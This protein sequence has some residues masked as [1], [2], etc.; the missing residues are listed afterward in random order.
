M[1]RFRSLYLF[2]A[3][4]F[5]GGLFSLASAQATPTS[6]AKLQLSAFGGVSGVK[7]GY[8]DGKNLGIT[9]GADFSFWEFHRFHLAA[10]YRGT[11]AIDKGRADSQKVQLAGAQ[12][13]YPIGRFHPYGDFLFG[14]GEINYA[15]PGAQVPNTYIFY[16]YSSSDV[17]SPGAGIDIDL[18]PHFAF[19][20][21]AQ[22]ERYD[23]PVT[24]SGHLTAI[25]GTLGVVY[26]FHFKPYK[27]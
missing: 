26:R 17:S 21:D 13:S 11:L 18:T 4:L 23:T 1:Y 27:Q 3:A 7:T 14:R 10:E 16:T 9:A 25:S 2:P 6:S 24:T 22:F 20:A 19:K 12:V 8:L 15:A 5:T